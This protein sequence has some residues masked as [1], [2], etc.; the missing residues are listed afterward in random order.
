MGGGSKRGRVGICLTCCSVEKLLTEAVGRVRENL[1]TVEQRSS[2]DEQIQQQPQEQPAQVACAALAFLTRC[3][4]QESIEKHRYM[5]DDPCLSP[6]LTSPPGRRFTSTANSRMRTKGRYRRCRP[7]CTP[8]R[9]RS[10]V[11]ARLADLHLDK[12]FV[13]RQEDSRAGRAQHFL[14]SAFTFL[15]RKGR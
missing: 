7:N 13:A 1:V 10:L 2:F 11:L 15:M 8:C 12:E 9:S 4:S 6:A 3:L 14:P 5:S